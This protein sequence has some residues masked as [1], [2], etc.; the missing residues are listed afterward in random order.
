MNHGAGW[1]VIENMYPEP[2]EIVLSVI[3]ARRSA[4]FVAQYI[5]QLYVDRHASIR[6]RLEY[7]KSP[8]RY[9]Y[10]TKI[11]LY[12]GVMYC[13]QSPVLHAIYAQQ[14]SL[15]SETL[16]FTYRFLVREEPRGTPIFE[17][18]RR[19]VRVDV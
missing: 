17:S 3:S 6:E 11:G 10:R 8:T 1:I 12:S 13:G 14:I 15:G 9:P 7:K 2:T 18:K 19:S 4:A 16:D 5:E